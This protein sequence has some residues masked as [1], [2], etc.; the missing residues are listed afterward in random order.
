MESFVEGY[1][2]SFCAKDLGENNF[3]QTSWTRKLRNTDHLWQISERVGSKEGTYSKSKYIALLNEVIQT[4]TVLK[5]LRQRSTRSASSWHQKTTREVR[6]TRGKPSGKQTVA[7]SK[8]WTLPSTK[9]LWWV[10]FFFSWDDNPLLQRPNSCV[11]F[12]TWSL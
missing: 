11:V 9:A 5:S 7:S 10:F 2:S 3:K 8:P 1:A 4:W 12:R 6:A